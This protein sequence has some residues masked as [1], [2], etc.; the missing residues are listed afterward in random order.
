MFARTAFSCGV[1]EFEIVCSMLMFAVRDA[2][3]IFPFVHVSF[4]TQFD[5]FLRKFDEK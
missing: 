4:D 2:Q 1:C 5:N 3:R